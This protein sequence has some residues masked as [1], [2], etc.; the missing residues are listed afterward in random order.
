MTD[1]NW[2]FRPGSGPAAQDTGAHTR[3]AHLRELACVRTGERI[4]SLRVL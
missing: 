1:P 3:F 4:R 2:E